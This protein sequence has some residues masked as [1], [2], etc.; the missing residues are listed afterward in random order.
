MRARELGL[1]RPILDEVQ[2][3]AK[4]RRRLTL[5]EKY[6]A[7][8]AL[9]TQRR[10]AHAK[11]MIQERLGVPRGSTEPNPEVDKRLAVWIAEWQENEQKR[12]AFATEL[13]RKLLVRE[14]RSA[15]RVGVSRSKSQP[16]YRRA[17]KHGYLRP[18]HGLGG[19]SPH[20]ASPTV[21][22]P[23]GLG[24]PRTR[25]HKRLGRP[26]RVGDRE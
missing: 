13:E 15:S 25:P 6:E 11:A 18:E 3:E 12:K 14:A 2:R 19:S 1:A 9:R 16:I 10:I 26:G 8:E 5:R 23:V 22:S 7:R 21:G 24:R 20:A 4:R 17:M